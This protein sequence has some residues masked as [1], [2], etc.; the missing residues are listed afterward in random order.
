[1]T[2]KVSYYASPLPLTPFP[3]S[4]ML[5]SVH[6]VISDVFSLKEQI[7]LAR[8]FLMVIYLSH[9]LIRERLSG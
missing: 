7:F 6:A 2:P 4:Y 1:M 5:F 9:E 3:I 8:S